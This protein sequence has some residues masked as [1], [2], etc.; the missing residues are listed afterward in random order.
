MS[1]VGVA[2]FEVGKH[3]E[4]GGSC[5]GFQAVHA[6]SAENAYV[7]ALRGKCGKQVA[8]NVFCSVHDGLGV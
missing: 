6:T 3:A 5:D 4:D 1:A 8:Q 7:V 2:V